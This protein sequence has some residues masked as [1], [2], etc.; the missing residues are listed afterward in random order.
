MS[1]YSMI[2]RYVFSK[3]RRVGIIIYIRTYVKRDILFIANRKQKKK[4]EKKENILKI[5]RQ[6]SSVHLHIYYM[7]LYL[8]II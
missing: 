1:N 6:P 7:I 2:Y 5:Q 3:L 8:Y 4:K